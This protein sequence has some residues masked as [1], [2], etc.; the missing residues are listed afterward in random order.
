M[1]SPQHLDHLSHQLP[2]IHPIMSPQ[3]CQNYY[4]NINNWQPP[5]NQLKRRLSHQQLT[6]H[7]RS[8]QQ[9]T[10]Q[11]HYHLTQ[12]HS[13]HQQYTDTTTQY[14]LTTHP[15]HPPTHIYLQSITCL[16]YT[17]TDIWTIHNIWMTH[18]IWMIPLTGMYT[19][20]TN[21]QLTNIHTNLTYPSWMIHI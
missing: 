19:P 21:T 4:N 9:T 3:Y 13:P 20:Y 14:I 10:R 12:Q 17:L 1:Q 6:D 2:H 18:N 15:Q 16:Q 11:V 8:P 7:Q 5:V